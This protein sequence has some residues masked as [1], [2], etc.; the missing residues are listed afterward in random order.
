MLDRQFWFYLEPYVHI[1]PKNNR[2]LLYNPLNGGKIEIKDNPEL[3]EI[4]QQLAK[5]EQF[6]IVELT[7][8]EIKRPKISNLLKNVRENFMGD[9]LEKNISCQKP[10]Q[11][12]PVYHL[13]QD[14]EL[15]EK[16]EPSLLIPEAQAHLHEILLYINNSC[17][18]NCDLCNLACKQ[19]THCTAVEG[20]RQELDINIINKIFQC[21]KNIDM[22]RCTISGGN[23]FEY[24]HYDS[25]IDL[26][27]NFNFIKEFFV[28][29][30]N[31]TKTY[32]DKINTIKQNNI[33][34]S[35]GIHFPI[36]KTL[37]SQAQSLIEK[38]NIETKYSVLIANEMDLSKLESL[39]TE[40]KITKYS[41]HPYF[42]S[43]N[44]DFFK[45]YVY[46]STKDIVDARPTQKDI[47]RRNIINTNFFGKLI[48]MSDG[49]VYGSLNKKSLGNIHTRK[50]FDFVLKELVSRES[51]RLTRS[52]TTPCKYCIY[53]LLCPPISDLELHSGQTNMC[54]LS[55]DI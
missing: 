39:L 49:S 53:E 1:A 17:T 29:Y 31:L 16:K 12:P 48:I 11:F 45:K 35:I 33:T 40:F 26:L 20:G 37:F 47:I 18:Q 5:L 28:H 44:V 9:I 46:S 6:R 30:S 8:N 23:I 7:E 32:C 15:L 38:Y 25:L 22:R 51:W 55:T 24:T 36:K 52:N 34:L 54:K 50:L 14:A 13:Q 3:L 41:I 42:N 27:R 21:T 2:C 19:Y 43:R 4:T 10:F